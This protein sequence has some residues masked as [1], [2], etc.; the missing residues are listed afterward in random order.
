MKDSCPQGDWLTEGRGSRSQQDVAD[1]VAIAKD[2]YRAIE[3]CRAKPSKETA[4]RILQLLEVPAA[5]VEEHI[6][7]LRQEQMP[8]G[9]EPY[10]WPP[11][12]H[13]PQ[14]ST[15]R[16]HRRFPVKLSYKTIALL[17]TLIFMLIALV[18]SA[19]MRFHRQ[20]INEIFEVRAN[21]MWN[22]TNIYI[23][24]GDHL[25]I[26]DTKQ[27]KWSIGRE[28][29]TGKIIQTDGNGRPDTSVFTAMPS[30]GFGTLIGRIGDSKP[31]GIGTNY[32]SVISL[33]GELELEMNDTGDF[34]DNTGSLIVRITVN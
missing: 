2:S 22:H 13:P 28:A 1:K 24:T 12:S 31:F 32:S 7:W 26:T 20:H 5:L 23:S 6:K 29:S 9:W 11:L 25:Y 21:R 17:C 33:T 8:E 34:E 16:P 4:R 30:L 27:N 10:K 14:I 19:F 3:S 15:P 18:S